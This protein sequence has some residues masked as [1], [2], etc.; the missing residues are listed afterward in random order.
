M[1]ISQWLLALVPVFC[2]LPAARGIVH[3][4]QLE[5]YQFPGYFRTLSRNKVHGWLPGLLVG[6][7][8]MALFYAFDVLSLR[9]GGQGLRLLSRALL[10][11]VAL[12]LGWLIRRLFQD[13]SPKKPLVFTGRVKRLYCVLFLVMLGISVGLAQSPLAILPCLWPLG[14]PL[15]VALGGLLAWPLE[16]GISEM[17]FRDAR[18]KLLSNPRLIRIGITGSYG[19]TSVK[20]ILG[21]I[22]SE[23]YTTLI[24]PASFNTPMGVSKAIREKLTPSYQ[25]FVG[26]MG[27]RHVGD[28]RELCRLVRPTIGILT[29]VGPQ[30]LDT[31]KTVQR[32]AKTKFE[33]MQALPKDG[34]G[35]F[36]DDGGICK[37]LYEGMDKP[38]SLVSLTPGQGDC[39]CEKIQVSP[40]GCTFELHLKGKGSIS[41]QTLLLGEHN[42][43]NILLASAVAGDLGL[44]LK[45]IAHGI[46]QLKPVKNRLELISH[47][48]SFTIINDAFN[49][50]PIG[51]KAALK[52]LASFP[53]RRIIITPGM[54]ELG[55]REAEYNREL[56]RSIADSADIAIIIGKKRALPIIEGLREGGFP[57]ENIHQVASLK[58]STSVLHGLVRPADT[59]L[60][61]NDL[62]DNYQEA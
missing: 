21:A 60:Y 53:Q 57:L 8:C 58:E 47:R 29:S 24:T 7:V 18:R 61:E 20:H 43:Q 10:L 45:Q 12:V 30:H 13:K 19:K 55:E 56:G 16:K 3:Y 1:T 23:K 9:E 50:N 14:L 27:A 62:P 52:V 41:C 39:W 4:F 2:S 6:V 11:P 25:V 5:S 38:K 28:I 15:V 40:S 22:L 54:V 35:Y 33:L 31:F 51:A 32:V 46:S 26:E 37:G 44:S 36:F 42:I 59:V 48:G 49:S 34:H 17:Y